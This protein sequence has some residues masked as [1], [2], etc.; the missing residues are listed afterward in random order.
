M[1]TAVSMGLCAGNTVENTGMFWLLLTYT[2]SM[3]YT[4]TELHK[5]RTFCL[6]P[7][8]TSEEAGGAQAA[9]RG[10]RWDS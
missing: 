6:S 5:I 2:M 10:L 7:L 9:Q 4:T 3:S 8:L 1:F